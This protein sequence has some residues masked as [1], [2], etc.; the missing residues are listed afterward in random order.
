MLLMF[1][2]R[3]QRRN[4]HAIHQYEK[5]NNKYMKHYSKN[6][7]S[8]YLKYWDVTNLYGGAMSQKLPVKKFEW[9]E[10]TSQFNEDFIKTIIKK[11]MKDILL[12]LMFN[13]L[14]NYM[15]FIMIYHFHQ[16][17]RKIKKLVTNLHDE[18][19]NVIHISIK[20][21]LSNGLILKKV[22]RVIKV[23]QKRLV[24]TLY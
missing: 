20:Q 24:K 2:K 12:K 18:T 3:N 17:K 1:E 11:M 4:F 22:H 23:S 8:S 7:E 15:N 6:S 9:I 21:S 5:A 19:E 14:K 10:D 16:K 13:I